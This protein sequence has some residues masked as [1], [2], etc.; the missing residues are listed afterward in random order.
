MFTVEMVFVEIIGM[1]TGIW[2]QG[3]KPLYPKAQT[4]RDSIKQ[5]FTGDSMD[6]S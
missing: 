4:V 6:I 1:D 3:F 2:Y 5:P